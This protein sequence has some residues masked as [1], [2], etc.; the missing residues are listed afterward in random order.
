MH[1]GYSIIRPP[2]L[3][4]INLDENVY[5][6]MRDG[7]QLAVDIYRPETAGLYPVILSMAPYMKE[8]QQQ[9]PELSH[10][11]EAGATGFFVPRGYIHVIAQV[12]GSG[13]SQ[14]RYNFFDKKE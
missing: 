2:K 13:F 1:E 12:R 7:V 6:P 9:P 10:C 14:G 4:N 11:I 3:K 8:M 5:L